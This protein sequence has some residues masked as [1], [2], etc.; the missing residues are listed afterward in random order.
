[1]RRNIRAGCC[2]GKGYGFGRVGIVAQDR[3]FD[4][5]AVAAAVWRY[6]QP[7]SRR[8]GAKGDYPGDVGADV[9]AVDRINGTVEHQG[10][11]GEL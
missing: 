9:E 4:G 3:E 2:H 1:M 10:A 6:R 11:V 7:V 5:G 8:C